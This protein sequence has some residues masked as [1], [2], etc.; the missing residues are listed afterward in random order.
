MKELSENRLVRLMALSCGRED[1]ERFAQEIKEDAVQRKEPTWKTAYRV[2]GQA[3][4]A[5]EIGG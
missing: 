4:F 2:Y 1:V 3:L 5:R